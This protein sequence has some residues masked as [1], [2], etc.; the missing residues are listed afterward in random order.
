MNTV[1][2]IRWNFVAWMIVCSMLAVRGAPVPVRGQYRVIDLGT[3]GGVPPGFERSEARGINGRGDIAG[4]STSDVGYQAARWRWNGTNYTIEALGKGEAYGISDDNFVVGLTDAG[5]GTLWTVF[6]TPTYF[7]LE[8]RLA[9]ISTA[10]STPVGWIYGKVTNPGY[11]YN[12]AFPQ[13]AAYFSLGAA[14]T[15]LAQRPEW[16]CVANAVNS[17]G[18]RIVGKVVTNVFGSSS[19]YHAWL[20]PDRDLHGTNTGISVALGVNSSGQ[21]VGYMNSQPMFWS[22]AT[23]MRVLKVPGGDPY[24][25]ALGVNDLGQAVGVLGSRAVLWVN[26]GRADETNIFLNDLPALGHGWNLQ[27]AYAINNRGEIVGYGLGPSG[28]TAFCLVPTNILARKIEG[29]AVVYARNSFG[30][31]TVNSLESAQVV[32]QQATLDG[33]WVT[34]YSTHANDTNGDFS[35]TVREPA[36]ARFRARVYLADR[37][38]LLVEVC[39]EPTEPNIAAWLETPEFTAPHDTRADIEMRINERLS[40]AYPNTTTYYFNGQQFTVPMPL[41]PPGL[42]A[43]D[44]SVNDGKFAHLAVIY[45][46]IRLA[47]RFARDELHLN[48]DFFSDALGTMKPVRV[49]AFSSAHL[50]TAY[51]PYFSLPA[52][53]TIF[54]NEEDSYYNPTWGADHRIHGG[55]RPTNCEF[56][57]YGH[58]IMWMMMGVAPFDLAAPSH[59]GLNNA[60]SSGSWVEGFAEFMGVAIADRMLDAR[61]R[62]RAGLYR[63]GA[64]LTDLNQFYAMD[65]P[66]RPGVQG[67]AQS[68]PTWRYEEFVVASLL[69]DFY[70]NRRKPFL[71]LNALM[72]TITQPSVVNVNELYLSLSNYAVA[73]PAELAETDVTTRF[74]SAGFYDDANNN[75]LFDAGETVGLTSWNPDYPHRPNFKAPLSTYVHVNAF[76]DAGNPLS[77]LRADMWTVTPPPWDGEEATNALMLLGEGPWE[78]PVIPPPPPSQLIIRLSHAGL[79][80]SAELSVDAEWFSTRQ[81]EAGPEELLLEHNFTL[82]RTALQTTRRPDGMIEISWPADVGNVV[83]EFATTFPATL[84]IPVSASPTIVDGV[85]KVTLSASDAARFF[86]LRAL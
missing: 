9:A 14:A 50:N 21:V 36:D 10:S 45:R 38:P 5:G 19:G 34:R 81:A 80:P 51:N 48:T 27:C 18:T 47:I 46:N 40:T 86:R 7:T 75:G 72:P 42:P 37:T 3:L 56:H 43:G 49:V 26:I 74:T 31:T 83:L 58:H 2:L 53:N 41:A 54:I 12:T 66:G 30:D 1:R 85:E 35:F 23:G 78:F 39:D 15:D 61:E 28:T 32:L 63:F 62:D 70:D 82:S 44:S 55:A 64:N 59:G 73:H 22:E 29:S 16:D 57:E 68:Q 33:T 52:W 17:S 71:P 8:K 6:G 76:D 13:H 67:N 84:W 77:N 4:L 79:R 60:L 65:H 25:Q 20:F 11:P 69:W 24:G